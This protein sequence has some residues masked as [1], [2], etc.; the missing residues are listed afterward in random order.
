M[1]SQRCCFSSMLYYASGDLSV[2]LITKGDKSLSFR[3]TWQL[4]QNQKRDEFLK[5][6]FYNQLLVLP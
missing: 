2:E 4:L 1:M 3:H 6:V 5:K